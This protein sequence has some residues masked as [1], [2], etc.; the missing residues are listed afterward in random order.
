MQI[1]SEI[2]NMKMLVG[3][4]I[5]HWWRVGFPDRLLPAFHL[6]GYDKPTPDKDKPKK[7]KNE[8]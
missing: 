4:C 3:A 8:R 1:I 2:Y 7:T 5:G 6:H